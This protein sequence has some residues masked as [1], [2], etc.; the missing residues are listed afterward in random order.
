MGQNVHPEPQA[1]EA[2][3]IFVAFYLT[4]LFFMLIGARLYPLRI[5]PTATHPDDEKVLYYWTLIIVLLGAWAVVVPGVAFVRFIRWY[6]PPPVETA[7]V[8]G[9]MNPDGTMLVVVEDPRY[10]PTQDEL[11]RAGVIP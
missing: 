7:N 1:G 6:S 11:R 2:D 4:G 3:V 9:L 8:C 5:D 10:L